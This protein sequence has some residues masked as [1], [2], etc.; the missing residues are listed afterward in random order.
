MAGYGWIRP[1][2]PSFRDVAKAWENYFSLL[3]SSPLLQA[4]FAWKWWGSGN[5]LTQAEMRL[6]KLLLGLTSE[7]TTLKN[8]STDAELSAARC[9]RLNGDLHLTIRPAALESAATVP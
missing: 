1:S 9:L 8:R 6:L 4:R 5:G 2:A 7:S 3:K